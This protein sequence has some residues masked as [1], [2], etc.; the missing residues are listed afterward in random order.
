[1]NDTD[2]LALALVHGREFGSDEGEVDAEMINDV[3]L[4]ATNRRR[5]SRRRR[6]REPRLVAATGMFVR[7]GSPLNSQ[8]SCRSLR[9]NP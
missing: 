9:D 6:S 7:C 5:V 1:L 8:V 4:A 3:K 2:P